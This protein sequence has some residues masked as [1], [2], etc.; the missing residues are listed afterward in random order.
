MWCPPETNAHFILSPSLMAFDWHAYLDLAEQ[1]TMDGASKEAE[2]KNRA[3][4]SRAYYAVY[5]IARDHAPAHVTERGGSS[6]RHLIDYFDNS[7]YQ[8][9]SNLLE[10]MRNRRNDADYEGDKYSMHPGQ[11]KMAAE[12]ATTEARKTLTKISNELP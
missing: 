10:S 12:T 1:L 7:G 9:I 11:W 2:A 5:N 8:S 4:V 6:H 3:A